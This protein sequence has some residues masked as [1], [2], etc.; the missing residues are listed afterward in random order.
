M[1]IALWRMMRTLLLLTLSSV[2]FP[3]ARLAVMPEISTSNIPLNLPAQKIGANDLLF[4]SVYD[5]PEFTRAVRVGADGLIRFP[6]MKSSIKAQDMLPLDLERTI[7]ASLASE[8]LIV[9]P[10]VTVSVIE[11]A[12]RPI[13]V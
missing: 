11:Y 6:M 2:A 9:D 5:A 7:A 13:N 4:V 8:D 10:F 12:S 3:Q 1:T